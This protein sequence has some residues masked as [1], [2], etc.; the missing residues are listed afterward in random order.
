MA[1][2]LVFG[3]QVCPGSFTAFLGC[4]LGLCGTKAPALSVAL[5]KPGR[6]PLLLVGVG[7]FCALGRGDFGESAL[8]P[9]IEACE[10][11]DPLLA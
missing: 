10:I 2:L 1:D 8:Q 11:A 3:K 7:E 5:E 6:L 4:G 9:R